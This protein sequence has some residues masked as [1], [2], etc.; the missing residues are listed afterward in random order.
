M[1]IQWLA[2]RPESYT[3]DVLWSGLSH[4]HSIVS[5]LEETRLQG[6][7]EAKDMMFASFDSECGSG[8]PMLLNYF[9]WYSCSADSFLDLFAKA[10]A[11]TNG[12]DAAFGQ[13]RKFRNKVSAHLSHVQPRKDNWET[14]SASLRQFITW[15]GG[16]YSVGREIT[17]KV[18][19]DSQS[20]ESS[21]LDWGWELTK[22]HEE[23][24]AFVRRNLP[25]T[26]TSEAGTT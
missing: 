9:L 1:N 26:S 19:G 6:H 15:D 3:L 4:L 11:T 22:I 25:H 2:A 10:F 8:V 20:S 13:M 16:R 5:K 24:D 7:P 14:Q 23:L 18:A 12:S 21:P 17:G